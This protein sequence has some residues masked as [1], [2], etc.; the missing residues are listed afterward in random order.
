MALTTHRKRLFVMNR[1]VFHVVLGLILVDCLVSPFVEQAI[2]WNDDTIFSTDYDTESAVTIVM[3]LVELVLAVVFVLCDV[4][5]IEP[6]VTKRRLVVF[7]FDF[8]NLLPGFSPESSSHGRV[9]RV[10]AD[11]LI[12]VKLLPVFWSNIW[13]RVRMPRFS[14]AQPEA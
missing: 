2:G 4:R 6:L 14:Y 5:V 7:E 12:G 1:K 3:L 13:G 8:D 9:Y 11:R 10:A